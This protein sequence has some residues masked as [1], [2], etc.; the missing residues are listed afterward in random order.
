MRLCPIRLSNSHV[1]TGADGAR[2]RADS[3]EEDER[4]HS[5]GMLCPGDASFNVPHQRGR[6]ECR[7]FCTPAVSCVKIKK[8]TVTTGTPNVSGIPCAMVYGL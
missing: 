6:R 4:L 7:A 1:I 5:R 2:I 8:H 3:N